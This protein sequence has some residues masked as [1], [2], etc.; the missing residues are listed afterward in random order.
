MYIVR[1]ILN[2]GDVR[3]INESYPYQV[4]HKF[5]LVNQLNKALLYTCKE[6]FLVAWKLIN[7]KFRHWGKSEMEKDILSIQLMDEKTLC[8]ETIDP[9][10]EIEKIRFKKTELFFNPKEFNRLKD[11]FYASSHYCYDKDNNWV[12]FFKTEEEYDSIVKIDY[13][14]RGLTSAISAVFL[15]RHPFRGR[16]IIPSCYRFYNGRQFMCFNQDILKL[17]LDSTIDECYRLPVYPDVNVP[18]MEKDMVEI[19]GE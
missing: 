19:L 18:V 9:D 3:Y 15:Y 7:R 2:N 13:Y 4:E 10:A 8:L 6:E 12:T 1:V 5:L 17:Y 11:C 14:K 16:S